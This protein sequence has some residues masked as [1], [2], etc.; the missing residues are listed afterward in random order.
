M[1][2]NFLMFGQARA[3]AEGPSLS[4]VSVFGQSRYICSFSADSERAREPMGKNESLQ[5]DL[6]ERPGK[7]ASNRAKNVF[8]LDH[9]VLSERERERHRDTEPKCG[10]S[11]AEFTLGR[12]LAVAGFGRE[13]C[14]GN[15]TQDRIDRNERLS[16]ACSNLLSTA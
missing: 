4:P 14:V 2:L 3:K 1:L 8:C 16:A 12:L 10:D 15:E 13:K 5:W 11:F 7:Q 6:D 9:S